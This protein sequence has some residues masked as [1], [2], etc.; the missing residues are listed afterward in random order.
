MEAIVLTLPMMVVLG[1]LAFTVVLFVSEV[2]RID[3]AAILVMVIL[4]LLSQVPGLE[5][6]ADVSQLFDG[7]A[8]NAVVSII[9][10]MIIGAGLD[11]TGMMSS[12]ALPVTV[13]VPSVIV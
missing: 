12:V 13:S 7:L 6:L 4:G 10:V 3:F 8:S 2:V 11:K 1:L 5:T 9:A